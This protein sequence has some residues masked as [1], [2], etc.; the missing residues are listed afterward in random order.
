MYD[1]Q[2]KS[3]AGKK[4]NVQFLLQFSV[5]FSHSKGSRGNTQVHLQF[6]LHRHYRYL[7][8]P[9]PKVLLQSQRQKVVAVLLEL[10]HPR[11]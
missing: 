9:F 8:L 1:I 3:R 6:R 11:R 7:H 4:F 10:M 5:T 2:K